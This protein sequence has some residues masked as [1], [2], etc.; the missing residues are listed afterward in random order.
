[1]KIDLNEYNQIRELYLHH[2]M[3]QRAIAKQLHISRNTVAKYCKGENVP[4]ERK[5]YTPRT[6]PVV[7]SEVK[8]FILQCFAEDE[9]HGFKKQKHTA[10][11]IHQRLVDEQGFTGSYTTIRRVVR[12][13]RDK[14]KEAFVPLEFDPGEAAQIDFGTAYAYIKGQRKKLKF[15]CMRLCFSG[16]FFVKAYYAENE[17]CFL[18]AHISSFKFFGAVPKRT[19]FDNAKVAVSEGLGAYVT[20]ETKRYEELKAHYQFN[21]T[22]CNPHSGNEKGLVENLVGYVRRNA[23]VPMPK[24]ESI[25]ELNEHLEVYCNDYLQHSIASRSGTVGENFL[26]EKATLL[27]LPLYHYSAEKVIYCEVNAYALITYQTNKYSV[28]TSY[29]GKEVC[30]KVGAMKI[31]VY[32]KTDIIATH[33]RQYGKNHRTYDIAH[34]IKLLESKPRAVFNAAPVRQYIPKEVLQTYASKKDGQKLLLAH[35]REVNEL[36]EIPDI[37]VIPTELDRYDQLIMEVNR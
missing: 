4:W 28:P 23:L 14:T 37:T 17:E 7:T 8:T 34:Y 19:I 32:H 16:H 5:E 3:S 10:K 36:K 15:F 26:L 27:P 22:Y 12:E 6:A 13:L 29:C 20:K 9:S 11:R 1:M 18:D 35:L 25:E 2:G 21:T 31:T 30:I 24:V 33:E